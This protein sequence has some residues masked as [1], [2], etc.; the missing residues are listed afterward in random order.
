MAVTS[1]QVRN[2]R[3]GDGS[4]TGRP[5]TVYDV[6]IKYKTPDGYKTYA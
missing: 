5:G 3:D 1:R 6:N 4:L 2:K